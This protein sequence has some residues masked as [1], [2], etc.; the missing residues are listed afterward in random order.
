MARHPRLARELEVKVRKDAAVLFLCRSAKRP[1]SAAEVAARAGWANAFNVL[2]GFEG[3]LDDRQHRG[4][5]AGWRLRGL[6]WVQD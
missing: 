2:E 5:V 3:D 1:A 4:S 6:P